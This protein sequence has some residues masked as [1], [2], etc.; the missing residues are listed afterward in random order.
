MYR[1]LISLILFLSVSCIALGQ[2]VTYRDETI[3][4]DDAPYAIMKRI[5]TIMPN[6]SIQNL[7]GEEFAMARYDKVA[8]N[9]QRYIITFIGDQK[10]GMMRADISFGKKLAKELVESH[11]L[12]NGKFN[13]DGEKRFLLA[14]PLP[15]ANADNA[16]ANSNSTDNKH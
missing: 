1:S 12:V 2:K 4:V 11:I 9:G 15:D 5:G 13:P 6:F 3:Y 14:N 8:G 10:K 16:P 7:N